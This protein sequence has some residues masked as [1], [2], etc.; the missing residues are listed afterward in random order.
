MFSK[1]KKNNREWSITAKLA[2]IYGISAFIMLFLATC[3]LYW[4]LNIGLQKENYQFLQYKTIV[5][6]E[7]LEETRNIKNLDDSLREEVILEPMLYHYLVRIVN[8]KNQITMETPGM[9]NNIPLL[10][11]KAILLKKPNTFKTMLWH[12]PQEAKS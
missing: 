2:W 4:I 7:I 3:Y 11:Y 5:L 6:Q 9:S 8:E 12:S 1:K 10:V